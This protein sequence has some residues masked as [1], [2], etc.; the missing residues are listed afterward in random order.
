MQLNPPIFINV[1]YSQSFV[2]EYP[3]CSRHKNIV[4]P[5]PTVD[6]D[7]YSGKL[8]MPGFP[9]IKRDKLIFYLGG[10]LTR[11]HHNCTSF[12][13]LLSCAAGNHGSCVFVREALTALSR[14][15][16]I[17]IQRG[18][19]KREEGFQSAVFCPIP[20]GDSPSSKRMYDVLNVSATWCIPCLILILITYMSL[21]VDFCWLW[22]CLVWVHPRRPVRRA[23]VGVL[24]GHRRAPAALA[25]LH[26]AA[27]ECRTEVRSTR[28]GQAACNCSL[29]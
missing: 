10:T 11:H 7:F 15:K 16:S 18:P 3:I 17:A 5:Y 25:V 14:D 26:P 28:A 22:L 29:R 1:E 4:A 12:S 20:I 8:F 23:G 9:N 27:P 6:P 19:R 24:G 2:Q 13:L 21:L